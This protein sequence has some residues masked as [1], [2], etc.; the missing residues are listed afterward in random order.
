MPEIIVTKPFKYAH[1]GHQVEAFEPAKRAITTTDDVA[2]LALAEGWAKK[3]RQAAPENKDAAGER[4]AKGEGVADADA[5]PEGADGAGG[6]DV[7][8]PGATDIEETP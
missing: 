1:R 8:L 5:D 6:S 4:S 2:Q 3:A 7:A